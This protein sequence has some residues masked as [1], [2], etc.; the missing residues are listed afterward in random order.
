MRK[1]HAHYYFTRLLTLCLL[2]MLLLFGLQTI[3][4]FRYSNA[5]FKTHS[6]EM[7]QKVSTAIQ[8]EV[9]TYLSQLDNQLDSIYQYA[10]FLGMLNNGSTLR[11][12]RPTLELLAQT[13]YFQQLRALYV[14]NN[15]DF[16]KSAYRRI[17]NHTPSDPYDVDDAN[18][19]QLRTYL[20]G[21]SDRFHVLLCT[22]KDGKPF[23]RII[24]RL[25]QDMG[26]TECGYLICDLSNTALEKIVLAAPCSR[27]QYVWLAETNGGRQYLSQSPNEKALAYMGTQDNR[28][29][30]YEAS[31]QGGHYL[32]TSSSS[33]GLRTC[34][35]T[36][37]AQLRASTQHLLSEL[38]RIVGIT[39]LLF[40]LFGI[41]SSWNVNRRMR[42]LI[43][44]TQAIGQ[45]H[46]ESRFVVKSHDEI[47]ILCES[48]NDMMDRIEMYTLEEAKAHK[49][50]EEAR[51]RALQSQVNPHF[52]YNTLDNIGAISDAQNCEIVGEMCQSLSKLLRY[53][54]QTDLDSKSVPL[55]E[56][57]QQV[58]AYMFII[59]VRMRG[60][61]QLEKCVEESV[62]DVLMPRLSVQ[63]L[64]ENAIRHG[65]RNNHGE[66]KLWIRAVAD[67]KEVR[68][69][70][71]DNGEDIDISAMRKIISGEMVKDDDRHTSIGL[72]NIH[73][74]VQMLFGPDYGLTAERVDELTCVTIRLPRKEENE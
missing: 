47:G 4:F 61:V 65:V 29:E 63:P 62:L 49:A 57:L 1:P 66:K 64:V 56:E 41:I 40:M 3:L 51:Y 30:Y 13:I 12:E 8:G 16:L 53:S 45:G 14:Y 20:E 38:V 33:Y 39:A 55:R 44:T 28:Q 10:K 50:L 5:Q 58:D 36:D 7:A 73:E 71:T 70:V 72:H 24:K 18:T 31:D 32:Q 11:Y 37:E 23:L 67:G 46:T 60:E 68:V 22:D 26:F 15:D 59:N 69:S 27:D 54:I 52:L 19:Q 2:V 9:D 17:K 34:M 42:G 21:S 74:R 6:T 25:Y 35:Y 48:F 43:S